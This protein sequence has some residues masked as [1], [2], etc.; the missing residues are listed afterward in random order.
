[1]TGVAVCVNEVATLCTGV[2]E[3]P[4]QNVEKNMFQK[5]YCERRRNRRN[6]RI[7]NL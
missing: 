3:S 7:G 4:P 2:K 5:K 6:I 1:M